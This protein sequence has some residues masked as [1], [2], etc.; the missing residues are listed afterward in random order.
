MT[1]PAIIP[2]LRYEDAPAAIDWLERAF[3][4]KRH[5]VHEDGGKVVHAEISHGD[6]MLMLA[7]TTGAEEHAA[8]PPKQVGGTVTGGIYVA[9]EDPDAHCARAREAGA[10]ILREP[11]DQPYGSRDYAARDPEGFVWSFGTYRPE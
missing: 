5:A 7:S 10:E 4:F 8:K 11:A 9:V 6:G 3:G 2:Y 1:W